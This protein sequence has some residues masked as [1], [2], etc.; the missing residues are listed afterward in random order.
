MLLPPL[1][2]LTVFEAVLR[3][4]G[5]RQA[6]AE[7]NVSQPAVSQALRQLEEHL[8]TKLLDRSSR[9]A[10]LTQAGR[11]LH[12]ATVDGLGR[13]SEAIEDIRRSSAAADA[14]ATIACSVG[15]AT[16]WLMPRLASFYDRNPEVAINVMTTQHGAPRLLPGV[17]IAIRYGKGH[18]SDGAVQRLFTERIDPVCSPAL[19]ERIGKEEAGFD[20]AP[21]IHVDVDDESWIGWPRYLRAIERVSGSKRQEL[22]FTNYVQAT[23]AALNQQG[24]MLG[25][26][27]ITA[28]LVGE[29]RLVRVLDAPLV[30]DEAFSMVVSQRPRSVRSCTLVAAWLREAADRFAG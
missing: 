6:A 10:G 4:G 7:L 20:S 29:G 8:A 5:I 15:F 9:P 28:D 16:H 19:A 18:W 21:L 22:H 3:Q 30:P 2:L 13:I 11:I 25:W 24:M 17:D 14:S 27:S 1:R 26:R 23:Q 12:R